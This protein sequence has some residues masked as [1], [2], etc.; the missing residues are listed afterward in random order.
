MTNDEHNK[1]GFMFLA[2][3]VAFYKTSLM[4]SEDPEAISSCDE[5][6][7]KMGAFSNQQPLKFMP[8][9]ESLNWSLDDPRW[10]LSDL[11]SFDGILD[12]CSM[13]CLLE[14]ALWTP[15]RVNNPNISGELTHSPGILMNN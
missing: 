2:R 13:F 7:D 12:V 5:K 1:H 10:H 9:I 3:I 4:G 8:F 14:L 11:G 6:I 15:L